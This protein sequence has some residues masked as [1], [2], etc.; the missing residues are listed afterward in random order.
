MPRCQ[1]GLHHGCHTG[2][3]RRTGSH[4]G[5]QG[6][7]GVHSNYSKAADRLLG[8]YAARLRYGVWTFVVCSTEKLTGK[9]AESRAHLQEIAYGKADAYD[10]AR[11]KKSAW[12]NE[13]VPLTIF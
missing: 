6:V 12:P 7:N 10:V 8:R 9:K 13:A 5:I 2:A 3:I 4:S 11:S 1:S